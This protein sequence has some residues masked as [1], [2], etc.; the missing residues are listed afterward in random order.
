MLF[1]LSS[2]RPLLATGLLL[3]AGLLLHGC[4]GI[5]ESDSNTTARVLTAITETPTHS[6]H[7]GK[8]I[9]HDLLTPD[10]AASRDFYEKL[11]GWTF[12]QKGD[13]VEI[14]NN[15]HKI[16]GIAR[17]APGNG[18]QPPPSSWLASMSVADVDAAVAKVRA[19]R[20]KVI[21]GPMDMPMR[22]RGALISDPHGAHLVLLHA[23]GGDPEDREPTMGDWLW[24]E[25]W[26]NVP[27]ETIAF[28]RNIGNYSDVRKGQDYAILVN[29]G[30]WR[31]GVRF[32]DG[33]ISIRWV[34]AIRVPDPG[35]MLPMVETLGGIVWVRPGDI[36]GNPGTALISDNTGALLILQQ[37]NISS[38]KGGR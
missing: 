16:G 20:G 31:A 33:D 36:P 29:E 21:N 17:V 7:P 9:W 19:Q 8:F 37:W 28:Y 1:S 14:Y 12:L 34:P 27:E 24:N 32:S 6:H 38:G 10:V 5:P 35:A 30:K 18:K 15:G 25:I 2:L 26:T 23:K 4:S 3:S 13:Y 11:L 22:G